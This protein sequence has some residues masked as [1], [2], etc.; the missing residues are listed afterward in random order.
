VIYSGLINRILIIILL[1]IKNEPR[2]TQ[3]KKEKTFLKFSAPP[4]LCGKKKFELK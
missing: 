1:K 3:R 2:E 4:R